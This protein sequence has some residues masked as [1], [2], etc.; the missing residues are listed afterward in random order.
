MI[1]TPSVSQQDTIPRKVVTNQDTTL[2]KSD[3]GSIVI[4]HLPKDSVRRK[5]NI[6]HQY[7]LPDYSDTTSVC[8][9]SII[10][11]VTF[12]DPN[13]FIFKIRTGTVKQ[14]PYVLTEKAM[15]RK[16]E[17][18]ALL[19]KQ[20]KPGKI[21]APHPLHADWMI[22]IIFVAAFL[23][24]LIRSTSNTLSY[25]FAKF[26]LFRGVKD[27]VS[28][29]SS[30]LFHWQATIMN[31][32]SF[33][34]IGLFGYSSASYYNLI[35]SGSKGIVIWLIVLGIVCAMV[36]IRH[37]TCVLTGA[38]SEQKEAFKDYLLSV[39][40]SYRFGAF[41]MFI[42]LILISYTHIF[43]AGDL[44]ISGLFIVGLIYLIR[45]IRLLVIFL[46]RNIS[47]FYLILYL[48]ALEIL[49]VLIVVKYF[50]GLA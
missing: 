22:I 45:F 3:S 35:P 40:Q 15:Q 47:I 2:G 21:L 11:D 50:T 37:I 27:P 41:F 20:L 7:I 30:G 36:T 39:Y 19:I 32:I 14:F 31:L 24:S 18:R 1:I 4:S 43:P 16:M 10:S 34:I 8:T 25:G 46:N 49:P 13:N 42:I 28:R 9:R 38:I 12:Y 23:F 33:F 17:E 26:F 6:I 48:C 5:A 44:I 29:D